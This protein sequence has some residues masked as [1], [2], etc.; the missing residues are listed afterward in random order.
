MSFMRVIG[1]FMVSDAVTSYWLALT[2]Q[3]NH[4]VE[5]VDWPVPDENVCIELVVHVCIA[6]CADAF[7]FTKGR[8]FA[9]ICLLACSVVMIRSL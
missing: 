4:V 1:L 6:Y 3:A 2:F 8:E 7:L 5:D 9:W